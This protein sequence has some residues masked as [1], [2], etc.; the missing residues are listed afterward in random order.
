MS[1]RA[2][3]SVGIFTLLLLFLL[4]ALGA[5]TPAL[6]SVRAPVGCAGGP[7]SAALPPKP[8]LPEVSAHST[9]CAYALCLDSANYARLLERLRLL[10]ADDNQV[11]A[12]CSADL[13]ADNRTP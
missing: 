11:R 3:R 7:P 4:G 2:Q 1:N 8:Y 5:C 13:A 6:V 10:E 12:L 9:D